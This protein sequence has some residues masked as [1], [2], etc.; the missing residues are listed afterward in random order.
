MTPTKRPRISE[1]DHPLAGRP[2]NGRL[3]MDPVLL[4]AVGQS[5]GPLGV[6]LV[7]LLA[8]RGPAS[9]TEILETN[10][11]HTST[12]I[13]KALYTLM[14]MQVA[15]YR[16]STDS[17]GWMTFTWHLNGDRLWQTLRHRAASQLLAARRRLE[18]ERATQFFR[19]AH[20]HRRLPFADA[21]DRNFRCPRCSGPMLPANGQAEQA[22]L[23][24]RIR[25]L[26]ARHAVLQRPWA[27]QWPASPQCG[28]DH[29]PQVGAP[30]I[31]A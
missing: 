5:C 21:M 23:G 28:L 29:S 8:S 4:T 27:K 20:G 16:A 30:T 3:Q 24:D 17:Q 1:K 11:Q 19:C 22:R 2:I 9:I 26:T 25:L 10:P 15:N 13:H 18:Y 14:Q 12:T 7:N 6:D 31:V